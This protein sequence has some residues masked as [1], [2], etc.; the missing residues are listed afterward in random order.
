MNNRDTSFGILYFACLL[1]FLAILSNCN[2]RNINTYS[3][4]NDGMSTDIIYEK[5]PDGFIIIGDK[6][7]ACFNK[8]YTKIKERKGSEYAFFIME[9]SRP[10]SIVRFKFDSI[11]L[12]YENLQFLMRMSWH[13]D[14]AI[15]FRESAE[16]IIYSPLNENISLPIQKLKRSDIIENCSSCFETTTYHGN[17]YDIPTI[18]YY[19]K[20]ISTIFAFNETITKSTSTDAMEIINDAYSCMTKAVEDFYKEQEDKKLEQ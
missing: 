14:K 19:K 2:E 1:S 11:I 4:L 13:S 16:E 7:E 10:Y 20:N 12:Q 15:K 5:A 6:F 8:R 9:Y 3:D 18:I 17:S